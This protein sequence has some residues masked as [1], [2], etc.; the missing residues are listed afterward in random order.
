MQ[1]GASIWRLLMVRW[2][3]GEWW[4]SFLKTRAETIHTL[5]RVVQRTTMK[6]S[7]ITL[8]GNFR[9]NKEV[10]GKAY[11]SSSSKDYH[12][13]FPY[14]LEIIIKLNRWFEISKVILKQ[15]IEKKRNKKNHRKGVSRI[16]RNPLCIFLNNIL[17]ETD[18]E[19]IPILRLF[20][21]LRTP[22]F[23]IS[24]SQP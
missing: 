10:Q 19:R 5:E 11:K 12:L 14:S 3:R 20:A 1:R 24:S 22:P 2:V 9:M 21:L 23:V 8:S 13:W 15:R 16:K 7:R 18:H 4:K 17:H 6:Y